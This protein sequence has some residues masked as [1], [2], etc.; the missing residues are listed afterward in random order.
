MNNVLEF[1]SSK[2][3]IIESKRARYEQLKIG[4]FEQN[5]SEAE[6]IEIDEIEQ[7]LKLHI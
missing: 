6:E 4:Y 1:K 2:N 7:W 3:K 5:L